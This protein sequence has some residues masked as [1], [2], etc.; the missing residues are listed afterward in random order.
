M[1]NLRHLLPVMVALAAGC[2]DSGTSP[3]DA[4]PHDSGTVEAMEAA[5]APSLDAPT[6]AVSD[7]TQSDL[8]GPAQDASACQGPNPALGCRSSPQACIPSSCACSEQG[9]ACT[10]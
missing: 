10:A 3:S 8:D 2:S 4:A 7:S 9:W 1:R 5:D 6:D